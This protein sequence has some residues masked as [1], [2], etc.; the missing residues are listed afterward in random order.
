MK[1]DLYQARVLSYDEEVD[2]ANG[3]QLLIFQ[4]KSGQWCGWCR[5]CHEAVAYLNDS[6]FHKMSLST[7]CLITGRRA[8][9]IRYVIEE[10]PG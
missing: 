4:R 5:F 10:L 6:W 9:P 1:Y 7:S 3:E 8:D 2:R